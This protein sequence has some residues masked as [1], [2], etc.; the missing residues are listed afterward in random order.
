MMP[1]QVATDI[2]IKVENGVEIEY[3][4]FAVPSKGEYI[5]LESP[6]MHGLFLVTAVEHKV[7]KPKKDDNLYSYVFVHVDRVHELKTKH[8]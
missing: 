2:T 8:S 1:Y 5:T 4:A 6:N 7:F 3:Q